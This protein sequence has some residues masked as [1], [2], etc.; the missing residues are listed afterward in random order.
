MQNNLNNLNTL[1]LVREEFYTDRTIGS[2]LYRTRLYV[3]TLEPPYYP[4]ENT[5]HNTVNTAVPFAAYRLKFH[6]SPRHGLQKLYLCDVPHR[7]GILIH[8]GNTPADTLGCILTGIDFRNSPNPAPPSVRSKPLPEA[9][10]LPTVKS[11]CTSPVN[12]ESH[13]NISQLQW[14]QR[15]SGLPDQRHKRI[16]SRQ[17]DRRI[18]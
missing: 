5:L 14:R 3:R 10:R 18:L 11:S 12:P 15:Q 1:I 13:E 2:I 6:D 16:R 17:S 8:A 9:S 4:S 7:S